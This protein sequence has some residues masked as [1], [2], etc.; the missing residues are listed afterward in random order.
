M[1]K[2]HRAWLAV[3]LW[4]IA[5]LAAGQPRPYI[6]F[7]YPAGG[8]QG[9]TV[10]L[11]LGGQGLDDV[12]VAQVSG[13]G[14]SAKVVEY[15]RKLGPQDMQLLGEQLRELRRA[16]KGSGIARLAT[17]GSAATGSDA[18]MMSDGG[19]GAASSAAGRGVPLMTRIETRMAEYVQ[20]PA[21]ASISSIVILEV[22]I[23]PNAEVGER[24]LTLT[25]PRG[26][27]N[28]LPFH[29]GQ[30]PE[31][32]RK[33]MLTAHFQ[34]LGKEELALRKRPDDEIEK[35]IELPCTVNGQI[36]SGEVN[37]YRFEARAGQRLVISA[38][39]RQLI[40]YIADAVPGWFQPVMVLQDAKGREVAYSDDYRFK[41]DP[42]ILCEIPYDGEYL[43]SIT[44]A[45][46][47]GREDFVYR[48]TIGEMPFVTSIFPLGGRLGAVP[49]IQTRGWNL[50]GAQIAPPAAGASAGIQ[51]L[52]ACRGGVCS[53]HVPFAL[54]TLPEALDKEPNNAVARAQK[55]TMPVIVNGRIDRSDDWDVFEVSGRKGDTLVAE[56][57]ARRLDSPLDSMLKLTDAR[58]KLLAFNDDW[59]DAG[60]GINTHDADSYLSFRLPADG[61]Y[62]VHLGDSARHG[63]EAYGYRLRI[64]PPRPDFAL[65]VVPSS[66][67][68]RSNSSGPLKV[69]VIRKDGFDGPIKLGLKDAPEGFSMFNASL[70]GTQVVAQV[71]VR[72]DLAETKE[73][74]TL[75]VV[76]RAQI[77]DREVLREA[78]PAE[79]RMQ[80]FLWRHL[81]PA[82]ELKAMVF[83][84]S[85]DP[86]FRRGRKRA[87]PKPPPKPATTTTTSTTPGK[88]TK[89]QIAGR[90]RQLRILHQDGLFTEDF[91]QRKVAECEAAQ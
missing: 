38:V 55:V 17:S 40:P 71:A 19:G 51:Q 64:S 8:Q 30:V 41:P 90:L 1:S 73:P 31:T 12:N 78:V 36:A 21:C 68:M 81:V 35:R 9:T 60:G 58:G 16:A 34:V 65:R 3:G 67:G 52:V 23:G 5:S 14:V 47:R 25:T 26:V 2:I 80:A 70:S 50:Q 63:G 75:H 61:S 18:M 59:E 24:E 91:Y 46:Y 29:V 7:V 77:G 69:Y 32:S 54:D 66:V 56:V 27:S 45:I 15:R 53:N 44:D 42:L 43:L 76:G 85:L 84:P 83:D 11:R 57:T 48:V 89:Q 79:D 4:A 20:R 39:A 62:F 6:G 72:T 10:Q 33:P 37:R 13:K 49:E 86:S 87:E 74:V 82:G 88:F 22:T 28:P